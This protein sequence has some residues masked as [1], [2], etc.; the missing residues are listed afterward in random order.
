LS[1]PT[2]PERLNSSSKQAIEARRA[3]TQRPHT[4]SIGNS[5]EQVSSTPTSPMS[6]DTPYMNKGSKRTASGA[7]KSSV[8]VSNQGAASPREI[9]QVNIPQPSS[10]IPTL[11]KSAGFLLPT[12]MR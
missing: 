10:V 3:Q 5:S 12:W 6:I 4:P 1:S 8:N 11:P 9:A 7:I 2:S